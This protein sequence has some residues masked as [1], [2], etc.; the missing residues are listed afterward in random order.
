MVNSSNAKLIPDD[1]IDQYAMKISEYKTLGVKP[2][3][4]RIISEKQ[5]ELFEFDMWH[6]F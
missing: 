2:K 1:K 4:Q 5:D 3:K 6:E